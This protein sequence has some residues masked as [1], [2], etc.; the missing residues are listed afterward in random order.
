MIDELTMDEYGR[1]VKTGPDQAIVECVEGRSGPVIPPMPEGVARASG[2]PKVCRDYLSANQ[3][4]RGCG[5]K[6]E[7]VHHLDPVHEKPELELDPDN[8]VSVD[9]PCH[10]V[11]CHAGDW[12]LT[13]PK[14][15]CLERLAANRAVV[16][17]ARGR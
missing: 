5:R 1:P 13:V 14:A 6:A 9:V 15:V 17:A 2:W 8:F 16:E 10:F 3:L 12:R 7:T 11:L 4:C